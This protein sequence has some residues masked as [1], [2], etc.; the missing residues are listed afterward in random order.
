MSNI[1]KA[2]EDSAFADNLLKE[3]EEIELYSHFKSTEDEVKKNILSKNYEEV[4]RILSGFKPAVDSFFDN[5]LVMD[6]DPAIRKNRIGLLKAITGV[7][8]GL[9]DFSRIVSNG[10]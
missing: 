2:E 1:V 7:F 3:K 5:V 10:E 4:Y 9:V 8:S 6:P